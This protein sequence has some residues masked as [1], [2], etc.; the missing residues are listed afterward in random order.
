MEVRILFGATK[1]GP[2]CTKAGD[3]PLQGTCGEFNSL[4]VHSGIVQRLSIGDFESSDI[5]S[6]PV[7]ATNDNCMYIINATRLGSC[8]YGR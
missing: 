8:E 6:N 5:G 4:R 1:Y 2:E 3:V 7:T